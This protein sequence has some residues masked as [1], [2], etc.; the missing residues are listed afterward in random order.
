MLFT[1]FFKHLKFV[2][3]EKSL[4]LRCIVIYSVAKNVYDLRITCRIIISYDKNRNV[5]QIKHF[6]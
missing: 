5:V 4:K 2:F 6:E 1:G 3:E